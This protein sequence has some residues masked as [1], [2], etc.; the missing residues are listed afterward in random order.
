MGDPWQ[1]RLREI[2]RYKALGSDV[3]KRDKEMSQAR[4][5]CGDR[6]SRKGENLEAGVKAMSSRMGVGGGG[7]SDCA[8]LQEGLSPWVPD[9]K[10]GQA[11]AGSGGQGSPDGQCY[12]R[13]TRS[14]YGDAKGTGQGP[15][16][17]HSSLGGGL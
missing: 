5:T 17:P 2:P 11:L 12:N 1:S 3:A 7:R 9:S 14:Q 15:R 6:A 16:A 4:K 13:I 8:H 10:L